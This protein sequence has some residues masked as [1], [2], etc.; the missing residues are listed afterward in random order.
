M[1]NRIFVGLL[2]SLVSVTM[3]GCGCGTP[4]VEE[5]TEMENVV[6]M[7]FEEEPTEEIVDEMEDYADSIT[8]VEGGD[9]EEVIE[10]TTEEVVEETTEVV[11]EEDANPYDIVD[12]DPV[13]K[14]TNTASNIRGIPDKKGE[15]I[16]SVSI[17]TQLTKTG[18]TSDG[19]WSRVEHN[20]MVCFIK[21]SLLSDSKTE[22]QTPSTSQ[23]SNPSPQTPQPSAPSNGNP[24][25]G[26]GTTAG[27]KPTG[28]T[29]GGH[30]G[31]GFGGAY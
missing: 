15:L 27:E 8:E 11:E 17:N 12:C 20:G 26:S 29:T 31:G 3:I 1:K 23:P 24:F 22:V 2:I 19:S 7:E 28:G 21:S 9:G 6:E 13:T 25:G 16:D 18:E 30:S 14:Y 10:E 5:T 4:N